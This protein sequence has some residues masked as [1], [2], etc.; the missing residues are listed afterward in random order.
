VLTFVVDECVS[1]QTLNLLK[2]LGFRVER[3]QDL[4]GPGIEDQEVF[5][6]AQEKKAVLLTYDRGFGNIRR[7]PPQYHNGVVVLKA[8]S[9]KSLQRCHKV[10]EKLLKREGDFKGTLFIVDENKYRK[11]K[12]R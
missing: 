6:I 8:Y 1:R 5:K 4:A 9:S 3:I 7:Y 11:R 2:S 10:L 12:S